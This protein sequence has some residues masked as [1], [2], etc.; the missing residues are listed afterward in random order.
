[1][2]LLTDIFPHSMTDNERGAVVNRNLSFLSLELTAAAESIS[3]KD[4]EANALFGAND[5]IIDNEDILVGSGNAITREQNGTTGAV[6][7]TG[8]MVRLKGGAEIATFTFDG[9]QSITGIWAGGNAP[10]AYQLK[11]G[12]SYGPMKFT[13]G[14]GQEVFLPF[15]GIQPENGD[16]IK[17]LAWTNQASMNAWAYVTR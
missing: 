8:A 1:M 12:S 6:H 14:L 11:F 5:I 3:L 7:K 15:S 4:G 13:G 16:T 17:V 9:S 10:G 2:S